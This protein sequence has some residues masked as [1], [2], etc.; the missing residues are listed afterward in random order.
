MSC[1][2]PFAVLFP[3]KMVLIAQAYVPFVAPR[4]V[5]AQ[6]LFA[7]VQLWRITFNE[8]VAWN[9]PPDVLLFAIRQFVATKPE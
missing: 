8:E 2:V 1:A 9:K 6:T 3:T 4:N 7:T 5:Y